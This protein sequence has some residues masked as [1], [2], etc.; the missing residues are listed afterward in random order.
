MRNVS[1]L[2]TIFHSTEAVGTHSTFSLEMPCGPRPSSS[3]LPRVL[4][5]D[6]LCC[7]TWILPRLAGKLQ[8]STSM[9]MHHQIYPAVGSLR[10]LINKTSLLQRARNGAMSPCGSPLSMFA[11][12]RSVRSFGG[13]IPGVT[14]FT[15]RRYAQL[16]RHKDLVANGGHG[17]ATKICYREGVKLT[18]TSI[19]YQPSG[20]RNVGLEKSGRVRIF[21]P[22]NFSWE[23]S[24][25]SEL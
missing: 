14:L 10:E 8:L 23:R 7:W 12:G 13:H 6:L 17:K 21:F 25:K 3:G 18:D 1:Y 16:A 22:R 9:S 20:I 2:Y 15:Y 4:D 24:E 19:G 5:Y 11:V